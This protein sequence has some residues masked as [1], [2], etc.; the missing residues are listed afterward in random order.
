MAPKLEHRDSMIRAY[1]ESN[2]DRSASSAV[3]AEEHAN[4]MKLLEAA[5]KGARNQLSEQSRLLGDTHQRVELLVGAQQ[6]MQTLVSAEIKKRKAHA[7]RCAEL[8]SPEAKKSLDEVLRA[9][10][11]ELEVELKRVAKTDTKVADRA[12]VQKELESARASR[13]ALDAQRKQ[14]QSEIAAAEAL[15]ASQEAELVVA[16]ERR[17]AA[18]DAAEERR[19]ELQQKIDDLKAAD[20]KRIELEQMMESISMAPPPGPATGLAGFSAFKPPP[21]PAAMPAGHDAAAGGF[22]L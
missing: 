5:L 17:K 20:A 19:A 7:A 3:R 1:N 15:K 12:D 10:G 2:G 8:E 13:A 11:K 4:H 9:K 18:E 22:S 6:R 14:V 21:K 16:K